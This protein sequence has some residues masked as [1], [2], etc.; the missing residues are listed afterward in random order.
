MQSEAI[1]L[2]NPGLDPLNAGPIAAAILWQ[3][4][5]ETLIFKNQLGLF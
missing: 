3:L 4:A 2:S 1:A 5:G